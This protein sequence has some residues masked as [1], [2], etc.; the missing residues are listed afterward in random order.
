MSG[1]RFSFD[2]FGREY[3]I[4]TPNSFTRALAAQQQDIAHDNLQSPMPVH[5]LNTISLNAESQPFVPPTL[6]HTSRTTDSSRT[7]PDWKQQHDLSSSKSGG[8]M[9]STKASEGTS[10]SVS[11]ESGGDGWNDSAVKGEKEQGKTYMS[12]DTRLGDSWWASTAWCECI[13][14]EVGDAD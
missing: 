12:S 9:D 10:K 8:N 13:G 11:T 5:D 14:D 4:T 7:T 3:S 2:P 6:Q 1:S